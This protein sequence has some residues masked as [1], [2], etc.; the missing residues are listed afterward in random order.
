MR[1]LGEKVN[2]ECSAN[3]MFF[4]LLML[5]QFLYLLFGINWDLNV[6]DEGFT[7][8]GAARV[9][10]GDV[11]YRDFWTI[12]APGQF[13]VLAGLFKLF[14]SSILVER[15]YDVLVRLALSVIVYLIAVKLTS[16]RI[17]L[18]PWFIVTLWLGSC[19]FY[20][21]SVFPAL[22]FSL[23]SV[24]CLLNYISQKRASW[25]IIS[26]FAVGITTIFRHDLGFYSFVCDGFILTD[27]AFAPRI[28]E[29]DSLG[30]KLLDIVKVELPFIVGV[31]VPT[32]PILSYLLSV[33]PIDALWSQLFVFPLTVLHRVR[34]LPYPPLLPNPL[35]IITGDLSA[36]S[37]VK[38]I[39]NIWIR[40]YLP[41][42]VYG[43]VSISVMVL[44]RRPGKVHRDQVR[45]WGMFLLILLGMAYFSQAMSRADSIHL[46]PTSILA[47]L[48]L[49]TLLSNIPRTVPRMHFVLP[50]FLLLLIISIPYLVIPARTYLTTV[51][52]FWPRACLSHLER[53]GCMHVRPDQEQA[54][55]YIQ[56]HTSEGDRIFVGN[57]RHDQIFA[58]DI[59]FYFLADRHSA[60]K[61]HELHPGVATTLSVQRAIVEDLKRYDVE[62][63]VLSSLFASVIEPN[64]S[65]ISSGITFLDDFLRRNYQLVE[66]FGHYTIWKK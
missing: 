11:P 25:L 7:V 59:M 9:L 2:P 54:I 39:L 16:R 42:L 57:S 62:Y 63:I 43:M 17:A 12:Y 35:P 26:G 5:C 34:S 60:T 1:G 38:F 18:I 61:Y 14:G 47:V 10:N 55:E 31:S 32:L 19:G 66:Q 52:L 50:I 45:T 3:R 53:A 51:S 15:I 56:S 30:N 29:S 8:Y 65:G 37:Y 23:L 20:S 58:N 41:L 13:Y 49:I 44:S 46:L 24:F 6:Y 4:Y 22:A 40:F 48:L 36:V 21:Y 64:E 33:V 28:R 27:F